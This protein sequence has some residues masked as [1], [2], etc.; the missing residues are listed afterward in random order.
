MSDKKDAVERYVAG[1]IPGTQL[2][3]KMFEDFPAS[4]G[5]APQDVG[6]NKPQTLLEVSG[7]SMLGR[8]ALNACY[9]LI[10]DKLDQESNKYVVNLSY[11]KWL[12]RFVSSNNLDHLEECLV[13]AQQTTIQARAEDPEDRSKKVWASV[14]LIGKVSI[15]RGKLFFEVDPAVKALIKEPN[16]KSFLSLRI[17]SAFKKRYAG[18]LYEKLLHH[19]EAMWT[20]WIEVEEFSPLWVALKGGA[21]EY[22]YLNR[23]VLTPCI[24]EINRISDLYVTQETETEDGSKKVLRFRFKIEP[25]PD[26]EM[27]IGAKEKSQIKELFEILSG[28]FGL[29]DRQI[30]DVQAM[31]S[32]A[33][34]EKLM[35][36]IEYTRSEIK[37][38]KVKIPAKYLLSALDGGWKLPRAPK[39]GLLIDHDNQTDQKPK[40]PAAPKATP[41]VDTF[42]CGAKTDNASALELWN[43]WR[44]STPAMVWIKRFS[45]TEDFAKG[46][47]VDDVRAAFDAFLEKKSKAFLLAAGPSKK[48]AKK[49]T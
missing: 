24:E 31:E 25:N 21:K 20:P 4:I 8:K 15:G 39:Q 44:R 7:L 38:G 1:S 45:L 2:A 36:A 23:D 22:K 33:N 28:E 17:V 47:E 27:V 34:I 32:G 5:D 43:E 40:E 29:S 37:K 42:L 3:L 6:F 13:E 14:Q 41:G 10:S 18:E 9:F 11:F 35:S 12:I 19:R 16:F 26:G 46:L 30:E 49:A 48:G